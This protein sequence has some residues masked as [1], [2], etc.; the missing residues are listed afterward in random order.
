MDWDDLRF[1]LAAAR[2]RTLS[3]AGARFGVTHTTVGRR[4]RACE[5]RLGV[6]LFDRQPD[7]LHATAAGQ[8]LIDLAERMEGEVLA[9]QGR[10]MGRD[11]ELRGPLRVSIFDFG[12]WGIHDAFASFI[13]R[14]PSVELT[15]TASL[16]PVS[17]TRREADVA[18]RLTR[19]PPEALIGRRVGDLTFAVYASEALVARVGADAPYADYPWLAW[20]DRLDG[21]WIH[22]WLSRNAPGARIALRIDESAIL[23]RQAICSGMGVFFM[24]CCVADAIPGI[25]RLGPIHFRQPLWLLTL[26]E[27]QHTSRV[28]A[29]L[30]HMAD[31]LATHPAVVRSSEQEGGRER[32]GAAVR[33]SKRAR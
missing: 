26:R 25:R 9:A 7:G 17:L 8:D 29:F 32:R 28:R 5:A 15:I 21:S 11:A 3:G 14:Y 27:L 13:A 23:Q 18:L 10:I 31:A 30:D 4:I 6:R 2:S 24:P 33:R 20:D 16:D 12:F 1:I 19:S 22:E